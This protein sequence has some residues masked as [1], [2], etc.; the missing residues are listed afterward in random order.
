MPASSTRAENL[1]FGSGT[2]LDTAR[3]RYQ[4]GKR[5]NVALQD[6][7][8]YVIGEHGDSEFIVW[9]SAFIGGIALTE[10]P[11]PEGVTL[12]QIQQ[13]YAE[14]TR[15]RGNNILERKGNTSYGI[16]TVVCQLVD[17][18]LRDEKQIFPV[19]AR[20]DFNYGVGSEIV[21]GLPCIISSIGIERQLVLPRNAHEQRLLE[22]SASKLNEAY[23]SGT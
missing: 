3:L 5:L 21:L 18:I 6:V 13:E 10:F 23:N 1:I 11:I 12:E 22:E 2:V 19:S 7:H 17:S 20:A 16:S 15:K 9:S 8:V 4:L 14:L